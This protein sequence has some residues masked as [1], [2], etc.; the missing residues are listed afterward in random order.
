MEI[1]YREMEALKSLPIQQTKQTLERMVGTLGDKL[2][3]YRC[4]DPDGKL[5]CFRAAALFGNRAWDMLAGATG[6]ARKTYAS[7]ATLWA[8]TNHCQ[9]LG[10]AIY[11]LSGVDP[12]HNKG[13]FDF[14]S[15]IGSEIVEC[16]GEWEWASHP[17]LARLANWFIARNA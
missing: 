6:L 4:L 11:D 12:V 9:K 8:L 13:V 14:K 17:L 15:G 16:L 3:V 7:Y 5:T 2:I 10:A 1:I